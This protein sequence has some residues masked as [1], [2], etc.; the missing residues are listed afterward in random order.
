MLRKAEWI[1]LQILHLIVS[2]LHEQHQLFSMEF[3]SVL[4]FYI[5]QVV[6]ISAILF[7]SLVV[8][9]KITK[10]FHVLIHLL[11]IIREYQI[12][13]SF[14]HV[15][16]VENP[17]LHLLNSSMDVKE[18]QYLIIPFRNSLFVILNIKKIMSSFSYFSNLLLGFVFEGL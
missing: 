7:N 17:H 12:K 14:L 9:N 2:T 16:Q 5:G 13:L 6:F 11:L 1:L 18:I 8:V 3:Y 4:F 10:S 15:L